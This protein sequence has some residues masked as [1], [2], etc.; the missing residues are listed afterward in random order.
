MGEVSRMQESVEFGMTLFCLEFEVRLELRL[1][2][3]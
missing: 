3:S 1:G 2:G